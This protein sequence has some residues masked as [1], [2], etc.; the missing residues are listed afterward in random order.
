[1]GGAVLP[2]YSLASG[3][4]IIA[5]IET[6]PKGLM[7]SLPG[8]LLPVPLTPQQSTMDPHICQ[9]LPNTHRQVWLSLLWGH[10][11]FLMDP[12][13]WILFV[14]FRSLCFP[15]PVEFLWSHWPSMSDSLGILSL[16]WIPRLESRLW[17]LELSKQCKTFFGIIVL[18]FVG[19]PPGS[20]VVG[21][22]AISSKRIYATGCVWGAHIPASI[23]LG[24]DFSCVMGQGLFC[25]SILISNIKIGTFSTVI[26]WGFNKLI[27]VVRTIIH[28]TWWLF[29]LLHFVHTECFTNQRFM[30]TLHR[31]SLSV[32]FIQQHL[33]SSCI[34]VTFW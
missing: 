29:A 1:M 10:C 11:S 15:S 23:C 25:L 6:P 18:Q 13:H 12:V 24:S 22:V 20:S 8:P 16:C 3:Q 33:L 4:T 31:A 28:L 26:W 17:C 34:F 27:C 30:P 19:H 9:R 21:L 14:P 7:L 2:L 32:S 5:V